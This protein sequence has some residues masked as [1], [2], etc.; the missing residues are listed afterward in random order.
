MIKAIVPIQA[1]S[2]GLKRKDFLDLCGKPMF[3]WPI[4]ACYESQLIDEV[5][6]STNFDH[7]FDVIKKFFP[8]IRRITRPIDLHGEVELLSVMKS[9]AKKV[10]LPGDIFVQVQANKPLTKAKDID[11]YL[12]EFISRKLNSLFQSQR[13]CRAINGEYKRSRR[14][15]KENYVSCSIAKIWDY[16]TLLGADDGTWGKGVKHCNYLVPNHHIEVDSEID[17]KMAIALKQGGL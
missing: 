6:L 7:A 12:N 11:E 4:K 10:G 8:D 3:Y 1:I 15:G 17:L 2:Q 14:E 5:Y 16:S 9:A 13:I